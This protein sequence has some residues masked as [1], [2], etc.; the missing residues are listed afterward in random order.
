MLL[1]CGAVVLPAVGC[2]GRLDVVASPS[3]ASLASSSDST[4][5][6]SCVAVGECRVVSYCRVRVHVSQSAR[7]GYAPLARR[8]RS[9]RRRDRFRRGDRPPRPRVGSAAGPASA[10]N[11][12]RTL[13]AKR[14]RQG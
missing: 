2:G 3:L 5:L 11:T 7:W 1:G 6:L 14:I 12:N 13:T 10:V 4:L 9:P 8:R